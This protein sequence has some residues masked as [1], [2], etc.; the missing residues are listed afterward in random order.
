MIVAG[1]DVPDAELEKFPKRKRRRGLRLCL[2]SAEEWALAGS[3]AYLDGMAA[4]ELG[5][6]RLNINLDT[7]AGDAT[8]TALVSDFPLLEPFVTGAL[9]AIGERVG[10]YLPLMPNSDHANFAAHGIPALRLVAGFGHARSNI[11]RILTAGDTR[12]RVNERDLR[13]AACV[14]AA[15]AWRGLNASSPDLTDL[16]A[17]TMPR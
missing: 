6:L 1:K 11:A 4:D 14:A 15:L 9:D 16:T 17:R 7:V 13:R 3:R 10:L 2:F 12:D 8:L 5:R